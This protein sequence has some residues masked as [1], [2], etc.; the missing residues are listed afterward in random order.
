M[1]T[2]IILDL[3]DIN[4]SFKKLFH[5][6]FL[7]LV[8]PRE[9][10]VKTSVPLVVDVMKSGV[11]RSRPETP[12]ESHSVVI[13]FNARHSLINHD[14]LEHHSLA[15]YL[16]GTVPSLNLTLEL[17]IKHGQKLEWGPQFFHI[18]DAELR[19]CDEDSEFRKSLLLKL[20]EIRARKIAQ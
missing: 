13:Y 16:S 7:L 11:L 3:C 12:W 6:S 14:S 4:H 2:G 10:C 18:C 8:C 1:T 17:A 20:W 15:E 19:K 5:Q 9:V